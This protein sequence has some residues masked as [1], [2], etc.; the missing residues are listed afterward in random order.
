MPSYTMSMLYLGNLAELDTVDGNGSA[1]NQA[2]LLGTYYGPGDAAANHIV[3]VTATDND[4]DASIEGNDIAGTETI[5][6]DLGAGLVTTQYDAIFNVNVTVEFLP[7]GVPDYSGLG[8]IVQTETGDVFM[9]MIDDDYGLGANDLDD[10]PVEA[11]TINSIASFGTAQNPSASDGQS[12]VPCFAAGTRIATARGAVAVEQLRAGDRVETLDNGL[13]EVVWT[14]CN[15]LSRAHLLAKP[16]L[17]PVHIAAGALGGGYPRRDL[18][19]SPQHRLL[20]KSPIIA[21]M[22]GE[23]EVL[24]GCQRAAGL[25]GITRFLPGLGVQYHHFLL[26][27]HEVVRAEGAPCESLY[28]AP[29]SLKGLTPAAQ[30]E[31]SW[32]LP[33]AARA[34]EAGR[35]PPARL[36]PDKQARLRRMVQRHAW[37]KRPLLTAGRLW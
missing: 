19:L 11:V 6:Y 29:E 25:P 2:A 13:Q 35:G 21:R 4:N 28:L 31:I 20:L 16:S 15:R 14:G 33:S 17:C 23:P 10:Y 8:G 9:V 3:D 12:F 30:R 24:V 1:E 7:G 5:T 37:N 36:L 27:H 32:L 34:A 26:D 22:F 18:V